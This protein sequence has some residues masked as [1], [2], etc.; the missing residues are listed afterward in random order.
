MKIKFVQ[1]ANRQQEHGYN[2]C[3]LSDIFATTTNKSRC[4]VFKL[5]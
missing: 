2:H 1:N 4:Q 3:R 5:E